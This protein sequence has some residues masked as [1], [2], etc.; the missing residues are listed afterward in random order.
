MKRPSS[1]AFAIRDLHPR[2]VRLQLSRPSVSA[3]SAEMNGR[4][5]KCG[6][7][8][9]VGGSMVGGVISKAPIIWWRHAISVL[10]LI[11]PQNL[12]PVSQNTAA[13]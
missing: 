7:G 13:A 11:V 10:L 1:L 9:T 4:T 5:Q 3:N 2:C 6:T 12:H 8:R